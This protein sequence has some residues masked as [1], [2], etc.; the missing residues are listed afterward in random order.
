MPGREMAVAPRLRG[1][2]GESAD[3]A[4][5]PNRRIDR[6]HGEVDGFVVAGPG[7]DV[8]HRPDGAERG[9]DLRR[10]AWILH[11]SSRERAPNVVIPN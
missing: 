11:S 2:R 7:T 3:D 4:E 9:A 10:D 6:N 1:P 5:H 8:D